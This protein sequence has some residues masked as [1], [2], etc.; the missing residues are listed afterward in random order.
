MEE[1]WHS[2]VWHNPVQQWVISLSIVVLTALFAGLLYRILNHFLHQIARRTPTRLDD[3]I[4]E[5]IRRPAILGIVLAGLWFAL[6]RL[7]FTDIIDR[8]IAKAFVI[9]IAL[10]ITWAVTR[11]VS[12]LIRE[13]LMPYAQRDDNSLDIQRIK[14]LQQL[15]VLFIWALGIILGLQQAGFD[16]AALI[17]GLGI[18]GIA[19]ALAAQDTVKNMLGGLILFMDKPFRLGDRIV[20]EGFDGHVQDIGI[21]STRIKTLEGRIVTIPNAHFTEKPIENITTGPAFRVATNLGLVYHT[22][23]EKLQEAI[24]IL[25]QIASSRDDL[26]EGTCAFLEGFGEY[27]L[28]IRFLYYIKP[29]ADIFR[30]RN[31]INF[32]ILKRFRQA[33]LEFAYPT[34]TIF[35]E[36]N[37]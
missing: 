35:M 32:E 30:V 33:G 27:A 21:R 5:Q 14:L 15:S 29:G 19:I 17:A 31:E 23:H 25:Q 10:N 2:E 26:E 8:R 6:E 16:V 12:A 9:L 36:N 13:V 22:S 4:L 3:I 24:T 28:N 11:V 7:H 18:G 1:W 20:I 37:T 34:R